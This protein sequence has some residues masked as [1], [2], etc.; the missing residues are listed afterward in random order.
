MTTKE[1]Q[2]I[3]ILIPNPSRS[4]LI[5]QQMRQKY[6]LPEISLDDKPIEEIFLEDKI[7][8]L[9]DFRKEI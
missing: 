4:F 9:E 8:H 5:V 1:S 2:L 6:N 3:G 7:I